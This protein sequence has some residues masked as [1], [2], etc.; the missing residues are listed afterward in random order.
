MG[1]DNSSTALYPQITFLIFIMYPVLPYLLFTP[2]LL[3]NPPCN[4]MTP[5]SVTL[6]ILKLETC[7]LPKQLEG[8]SSVH[9]VDGEL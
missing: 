7:S 9:Y 8:V 2:Y 1:G 6:E 5:F 4:Q 3:L